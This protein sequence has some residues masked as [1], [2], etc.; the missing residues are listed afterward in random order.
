MERSEMAE[1]ALFKACEFLRNH[2][3]ADALYMDDPEI[4]YLIVDSHSD[5]KGL[6]WLRY[7]LNQVLEENQKED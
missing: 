1:K 5:P 3:P 6:K 2:P 4:I 7:F